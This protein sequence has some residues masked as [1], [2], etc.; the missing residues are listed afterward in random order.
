MD[1]VSYH[2]KLTDIEVV[3]ELISDCPFESKKLQFIGRVV[4]FTSAESSAGIC[5]YPHLSI[6][7]L[8]Q[9]CTKA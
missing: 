1:V 3:P 4:L 6:L 8:I 7:H 9:S 2:S 5:N